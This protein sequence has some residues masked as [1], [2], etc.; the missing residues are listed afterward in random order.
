MLISCNS[1]NPTVPPTITKINSSSNFNSNKQETF[2][3]EYNS[4]ES[5]DTRVSWF[6]DGIVL[7]RETTTQ[8]STSAGKTQITFDPIR[9]SDKGEYHVVIENIHRIIPI[10]QSRAE[11]RFTVNVTILPANLTRLNA[12]DI[13][14][15]SATLTWSASPNHEDELAD[16]YTITVNYMNKSLVH[17]V[18]GEARHHPLT[19]VPGEMHYVK[20]EANNQDGSVSSQHSFP[21]LPGG[22]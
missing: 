18:G 21:A 13:T 2:V 17:V 1:L 3:V 12:E 11:G 7:D 22:E 6:K 9:R 8:Q 15:H 10:N 19:L 4:K 20:V 5:A 16:N 14:N